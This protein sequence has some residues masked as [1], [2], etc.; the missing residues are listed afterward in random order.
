MKLYSKFLLF[1]T[2]RHLKLSSAEWQP[3]CH[4]LNVLTLTAQYRINPTLLSDDVKQRGVRLFDCTV[5]FV[6]I[7]IARGVRLPFMTKFVKIFLITRWKEH[8]DNLIISFAILD[9][10]VYR[11]LE[12]CITPPNCIFFHN[13]VLIIG[14]VSPKSALLINRWPVAWLRG[15]TLVSQNLFLEIW[16]AIRI[17][18]QHWDGT[19]LWI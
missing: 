14:F 18:S 3:F 2:R 19:C 17:I 15:L 12:L 11:T 6:R 7:P 13:H 5:S 8:L 1:H 4:G 16:R 10:V 9:F